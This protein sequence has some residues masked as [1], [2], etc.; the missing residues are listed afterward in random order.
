VSPEPLPAQ[1]REAARPAF[2]RK[3]VSLSL[4]PSCPLPASVPVFRDFARGHK[5]PGDGP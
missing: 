4:P 3:K 2:F 5:E 1:V